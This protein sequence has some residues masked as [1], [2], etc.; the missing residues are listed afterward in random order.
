MCNITIRLIH[1]RDLCASKNLTS[2]LEFY[3]FQL[4]VCVC[5]F[6]ALKACMQVLWNQIGLQ[7]PIELSTGLYFFFTKKFSRFFESICL[8]VCLF[9]L[10]PLQKASSSSELVVMWWMKKTRIVY[11][12]IRSYIEI[13]ARPFC[14]C[15]FVIYLGISCR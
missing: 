1:Q 12:I 9:R 8:F 4:C 15:V 3:P 13:Y 14:E 5:V 6:C 10:F 7:M 11:I 2:F